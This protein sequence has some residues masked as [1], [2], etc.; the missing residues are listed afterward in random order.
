M[1]IKT[2]TLETLLVI[3]TIGISHFLIIKNQK[4]HAMAQKDALARLTKS[5][6]DLTTAEESQTALLNSIAQQIR[7]NIDD[8]AELNALADSLDKDTAE[9]NAAIAANT[10][11]APT[12]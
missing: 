5:V 1:E 11:A 3:L 12:A 6:Q 9:I 2:L 10:P 7:D 4:Q 8:S